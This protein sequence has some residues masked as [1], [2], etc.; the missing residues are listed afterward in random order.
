MYKYYYTTD[1]DSTMNYQKIYDNLIKSRQQNIL[2]NNV[3]NENHHIIPVCMG[4]SNSKDNLVRLTPREHYM[5]HALLYKIHKTSKMAHAWFCMTRS[6]FC[7]ERFVT[8]RQYDITRKALSSALKESMKGSGNHFYGKK[9]TSE[10]KQ[11]IGIAN[12]RETRSPEQINAWIENIAKKPKSLDHRKKIA[13]PGLIML[14]NINTGESVRINKD[15]IG[16][17]D[18]T[19]WKNPSSINQKRVVCQ[20]CGIESTAGN[21]KRWHNE[22]CKHN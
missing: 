2:N 9:H 14:K 7:N 5:A 19:I 10:S 12:S 1:K 20:K 13:R 16:S 6:S 4:G 17:Y 3:S 18:K 8:S 11:K 15:D 21:I 22:K